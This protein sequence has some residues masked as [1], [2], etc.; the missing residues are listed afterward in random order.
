MTLLLPFRRIKSGFSQTARTA[1]KI[2]NLLIFLGVSQFIQAQTENKLATTSTGSAGFAKERFTFKGREAWVVNPLKPMPGNPWIW[3]AHFPDWHTGIDSILLSKGFHIAYVNTNDMFANDTAMAVWDEFYTYLTG[4]LHFSEKVVLEGVSRGG[5]YVYTWAKVH[6][7]KVVA[8][9]A[10]A[11]VCDI[12]SWP[13]GTTNGKGDSAQA[14]N[15]LKRFGFK[16][17]D[18]ASKYANNPLDNLEIL[19][20]YQIPVIHTIGLNDKIVPP[21]ENTYL[22]INKYI[23]LGGIATVIPCIDKN[24]TLEGH[25]FKIEKAPLIA[26]MLLI[27]IARNN[28][29]P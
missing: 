7:E 6:P 15:L 27:Y 24:E 9:Y 12:K 14:E 17:K 29:K 19:A 26:D 23:R 11:P 25:H 16:T 3:R 10:E 20:K 5:I 22:L 13:L 1:C 8:I 2:I 18:E 28:L 21:E 4:T